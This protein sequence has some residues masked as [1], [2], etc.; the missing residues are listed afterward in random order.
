[1][2]V[3]PVVLGQILDPDLVTQSH[4]FLFQHCKSDWLDDMSKQ[5]R[6]FSKRNVYMKSV[7]G[8]LSES[9]SLMISQRGVNTIIFGFVPFF[10]IRND[11]LWLAELTRFFALSVY[12]YQDHLRHKAMLKGIPPFH[13]HRS[14]FS[15]FINR[16][17]VAMYDSSCH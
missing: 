15:L 13:A 9:L 4:K 10:V 8:E 3:V 2:C 11:Y 7:V 1:M 5:L 12:Y 6:E 16:P 14:S 17:L